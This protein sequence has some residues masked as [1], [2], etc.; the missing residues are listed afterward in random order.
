MLPSQEAA[1][2]QQLLSS[3]PPEIQDQAIKITRKLIVL[4][5]PAIFTRMIEGPVVRTF[6]FQPT[7]F[8]KFSSIFSKA[9]EIAGTLS[10][11]SV[12]IER[13]L[14]ECTISVPRS[15]RQTI[16][17]DDCLHKMMTS[18]LTREMQLPLL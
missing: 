10:V 4:G 17:F 3:Y 11:E 13:I 5:F 2:N 9:E 6:Y 14:G 7:E 15:D 1:K 12:R 18:P 8:S 16:R